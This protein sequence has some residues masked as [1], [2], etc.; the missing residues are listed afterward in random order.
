MVATEKERFMNL[1]DFVA[2][3]LKQIVAGVSEAQEAIGK[4]I[5]NPILDTSDRGV[6][7][8]KPTVSINGY[9]LGV[10]ETV[11]FD[12]AVTVAKEGA[13]KAGIAVFAGWFGAGGQR[14]STKSDIVASRLKF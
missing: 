4:G 3:S 12:V 1:K 7:P 10:L 8:A 14:E 2:E 9:E 11:E 13:N 5:I 6:A